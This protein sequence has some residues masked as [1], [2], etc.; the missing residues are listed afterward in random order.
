MLEKQICKQRVSVLK[1]QTSSI[2]QGG[3]SA[4]QSNACSTLITTTDGPRTRPSTPAAPVELP[5][6]D[7]SDCG[8]NVQSP[9][10]HVC[11]CVNVA[12]E[13]AVS[14]TPLNK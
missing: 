5:D 6:G 10:V 11:N 13:Y 14:E 9:G 2:D 12:R 7:R 1:P 4:V 8:C 3:D